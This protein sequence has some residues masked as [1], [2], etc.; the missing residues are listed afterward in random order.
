MIY[1]PHQYYH[2]ELD[3]WS[4]AIAFHKDELR[5]AVRQLGVLLEKQIT[6]SV[7]VKE[8]G[9]FTD[10]LMAQ[11]Q[12]FDHITNQIISQQQRLEQT[13]SFPVNPVE[14]P[15]THQQD[16]LRSKMKNAEWNFVRIKYACSTFLSSF[17]SD[18]SLALQN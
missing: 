9:A 8:S 11:E 10:R 16:S 6:S 7:N 1:G 17:L 14:S 13:A 4:L 5:E 3:R 2:D 15:V 18:R 12:Q